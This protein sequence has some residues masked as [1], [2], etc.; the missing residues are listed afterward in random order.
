MKRK[1]RAKLIKL[2][3]FGIDFFIKVFGII[4]G[5][6]LIAIAFN[7]LIIPY[8]LLSGGIG[9]IALFAKYLFNIPVYFS[10][11]LLNIPIFIWGIK[12]LNGKFILYSMIGTVTF[13]LSLPILKPFIPVPNLDMIIVAIFAGVINGLGTGI[14]LKFGAS[15]GGT[16]I[17]AVIMKKK[18]NIQVG[19]FTFA[20]N[21]FVLAISS[22]FFHLN[23][24][25]YTV[26]TLWVSSKIMD[27]VLHGINRKKSIMI[28]SNKSEIIALRIIEELHRG[29]TF[30]NGEGGFKRKDQLV[31][32]T[33]VNNFENVKIR[34]IVEEVDRKAFMYI[35]EV[36]DVSGKG[37][38]LA[39]NGKKLPRDTFL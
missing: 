27:F 21:I 18:A 1:T 7:A 17:I 38:T 19:T 13:I 8:G 37:F 4:I 30:F 23:S 32:N 25:L 2:Q 33:V 14:V 12:D 39:V 36:I 5:S 6:V 15:G 28:F 35:T 3:R 10:V 22:V 26:V 20:F 11:F 24:I 29:I 9:G 31:I 16:D 34:K